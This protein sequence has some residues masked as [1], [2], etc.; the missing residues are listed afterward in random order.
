MCLQVVYR[1]YI[2]IA[3]PWFRSGLVGAKFAAKPERT[4]TYVHTCVSRSELDSAFCFSWPACIIKAYAFHCDSFRELELGLRIKKY[5]RDRREN[6]LPSHSKLQPIEHT[7]E[8]YRLKLSTFLLARSLARSFPEM[9]VALNNRKKNR[10][11]R[12]P[13]TIEHACS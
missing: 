8:S 5:K 10:E 6:F 1:D 13:A 3:Y 9:A 4:C 11:N 12:A 7:V 2:G